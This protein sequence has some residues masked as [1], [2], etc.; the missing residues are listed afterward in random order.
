MGKSINGK[1]LGKGF[2]QKKDGR[3]EARAI[4][5]G[6]KINLVSRDLSQ[7]KKDFEAAKNKILIGRATIIQPTLS[8]WYDEWFSRCKKP[9]LKNELSIGAYNR[10]AKN[11]FV[12]IL[13][14]KDIDKIIQLDIQDAANELADNGYT[15]RSIREALGIMRECFD[16]AVANG[17]ISFNPCV[18]ITLRDNNEHQ[19]PR[20]VLQLW[21]QDLLFE[22]TAGRYYEIPYKILLS[23]GMRI[24]EFSGL[25]WED[26]DFQNELIHINRS[27]STGYMNGKKIMK[28]S[29]PKTPNSY[30]NIPFFDETKDLFTKWKKMQDLRKK[31]LGTRWRSDPTFGN[32]VF[33]TT[34]GSPITRYNIV[35]DIKSV[36]RDMIILERLS[37]SKEG[38]Q[39]RLIEHIHPHA[40][41]HT[42][43]TRCFEKNMDPVVVQN[44][45]GHSNYSTTLSYTHL[46]D[47]KLKD[48]IKKVGNFLSN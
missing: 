16:V 18:C 36:E 5:N 15:I 48:E 24:G 10:K 33:T 22:V 20:R 8:E 46:L 40:F 38:R 17:K 2:T 29:S 28:L 3:Y 42:F 27:M 47:Q 6:N 45:M 32:L 34:M 4:I 19:K 13:G 7:L 35:H 31:E 43:A 12:E 11:T 14:E 21:E 26:V 41:R 39:P 44:I 1:E 23:T 25:Q 9:Q 37:A 30:R